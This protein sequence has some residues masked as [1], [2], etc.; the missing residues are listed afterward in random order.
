MKKQIVSS[1]VR[2]AFT[3]VML[4]IVIIS[5]SCSQKISFQNSSV[6]P[7]ARGNVTLK[8]DKNNNNSINLTV[9]D[10]AESSRLSP[11][12]NAYVVWM[13]TDQN[14]TKNI[15]Q[16]NSDKSGIANKL[17]ATFKT[18]SAFKPT[19]I[20]I[21]AENEADIQN[22]ADQIVLSTDFFNY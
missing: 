17:K 20:F 15:G 4:G 11:A 2:N 12:K 9:T 7:A 5:S 3:L 6:V 19:K 10:L 21:T 8:T 14:L 13:V 1:N 22:P 16:L 18:V